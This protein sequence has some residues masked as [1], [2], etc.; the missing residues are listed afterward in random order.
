M[1]SR[2]QVLV[3]LG[4]EILTAMATVS[5]AAG[6]AL[7]K[8]NRGASVTALAVPSNRMVGEA[9]AERHML[10]SNAEARTALAR[11]VEDPFVARVD[12]EWPKGGP[13]QTTYY[14]ARRSAAGLT[15]AIEGAAFVA[16][17]A[18]LGALAEYE[19][20]E[21]VIIEINGVDHKAR[22]VRRAI[23]TP[24][25]REG[26]W[27]A[28]LANFEIRNWGEIL[29]LLRAESLRIGL[30]GLKRKLAG[31]TEIED[32][33]G[34][35]LA[36]AAEADA[37][38]G[39]LRRKVVDRIALRDRP[40]L[41]KFQGEVYRLP[42]D[43]QVILF[44]PPG[45]GKTTTLIKRLAQK[46]TADALTERETGLVAAYDRARFV[47]PDSWAMFSPTEL[48]KEYLGAAFSKEGV[49]DDGNVRTWEKERHDLARNVFGILRT[50]SSGRFQLVERSFLIDPSSRGSAALHDGFA[51]YSETILTRRCDEA[52]AA[53]RS[54]EGD[55]IR[56]Q[57]LALANALGPEGRFSS[58]DVLRFLDSADGWQAEIRG[59]SEAISSGLNRTV[60]LLLNV[61]RSLLD[62]IAGSLPTLRGE[63]DD[64]VDEEADEQPAGAAENPKREA[65]ELVMATMRN[66]ARA[67]AEGRRSIGGRSG[68]VISLVGNRMP[69]AESLLDLGKQIALRARM[70]TLVQAP[71][72]SVLGLPTLYARF[73]RQVTREG[74]HFRAGE[75]A[76]RFIDRNL[77]ST[78]ELDALLLVMLRNVRRLI[79]YA[80]SRR[81]ESTAQ[82]DWLNTLR[83][84]FLT[85][86]FVDEATDLSAVQLACTI[87]LA[88]PALRSW[89]ACGDLRQRITGYGIRDEAEIEWLN[90]VS[91]TKIDVRSINIGYRQSE[92]LRELCDALALLLD[93]GDRQRT[94]AS[95]GSEEANAWP[96]LEEG[97]S[98]QPLA[99]WLA[100]RIGEVEDAVGRLPSI[101]I[102]VD[103]D[104]L[105]DP[106]VGCLQP[107]LAERNIPVA[108]CKEGKVVGDEREVRVFDVQHIKGLEFEAVFF[109]GADLLA[110]RLPDL[111]RRFVYVGMTRAATY[112]G[113]TCEGALPAGL[114]PL[115]SH[116]RTN[117]WVK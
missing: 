23:V 32:I 117:S 45:S 28:V 74:K 47:R 67:V 1:D 82:H 5:E 63:D 97:L 71:R 93:G 25:M 83:S 50:G 115:R 113:L 75:E 79:A 57:A 111:Y 105:I 12:V 42:L 59:L 20:G 15:T 78:G 18:K 90:R 27:D 80:D 4:D 9:K 68:R 112:L 91:E 92:K 22:I 85:Q 34:R 94:E 51:A 43:R 33:V 64:D 98:G 7:S 8:P 66:W 36:E 10:A 86:V 77:I 30:D 37:E 13:R 16:S 58:T 100:E 55:G 109:V 24:Q 41:N 48:L 107:L 31:P 102:F 46:R 84:R 56:R 21:T 6:I 103:G 89:F 101:A 70:R 108:G 3:N 53:L 73:R 62:E 110:E 96:L 95:K 14:F 49:P 39:R 54:A 76:G 11:L 44:G 72:S 26:L 88:D 35:L 38:R 114:E 60:N 65:L 99:R 2:D 40:V 19:A 106:L 52:L 116:F 69:P 81:I 104:A 29:E 87:E 17:G 61:N